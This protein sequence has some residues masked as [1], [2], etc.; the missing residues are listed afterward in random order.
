MICRF[1]FNAQSS[2]RTCRRIEVLQLDELDA[3]LRLLVR[4]SQK[5]SF[6]Q[7]IA[8][9]SNHNLVNKS[10][11]LMSLNPRLIDGIL[12]VGGRLEH[13]AVSNNRKHPYILDHRHPLAQLVMV[14]Y[15]RKLFHAGQQLLISAVRERFWLT[16]ARNLARKT[17]HECVPCFRVKPKIQEKLMADLPPD[18]VTPC[19]SFQKVGVD[20]CGPFQIAYPQRRS[21]PVKCFVAIYICLVT[22]AVH[23]ELVADLTTQAFLASLKR[24]SARRGKPTLIMCDNAKNFVGARREVHEL[25][26][27]FNSQQFQEAVIHGVE[28]DNIEFRFIPARS[29]NFG[30]LWESAVKAFKTLFKRTIGTR[31]L[32]YDEMQTVLVQIEAILNSR[33]LTP[34]SNDPTDYEALTPGHFLIQRPLTAIPEPNLE[35][36]PENRLSAWQRIQHYTQQLWKKWSHMYLSNL[37]NRTRWTRRRENLSVGTMV[38]LKEDNL[39]PLRWRLGRITEIH[40]GSDGNIRVVTVRTPDGSYQRAI[41]KVCVLP[42][43]D[44]NTLL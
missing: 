3:A 25:Q 35:H 32:I 2:N 1:R 36:L 42:I 43:R 17:I 19:V 37:Q 27:L 23:L 13:A 21:R 14:H 31:T 18:R 40:Q 38:V 28:N 26:R 5:E 16:N 24:F 22:K 12:C 39:P 15:H 7:E 34:I 33:P 4:L 44:N 20:Y 29:P 9:L 41:S 10:S 30:G 8:D 11:R 6:P